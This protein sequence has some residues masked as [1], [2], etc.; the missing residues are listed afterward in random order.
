MY[1]RGARGLGEQRVDRRRAQPRLWLIS[2]QN[3]YSVYRA[4]I[5]MYPGARPKSLCD[6]TIPVDTREIHHDRY[7]VSDARWSHTTHGT[8]ICVS[9]LYYLQLNISNARA[10]GRAR[11]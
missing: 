1:H 4:C 5:G 7:N 3:R 6:D 10:G 11:A 9:K 2:T 8:L